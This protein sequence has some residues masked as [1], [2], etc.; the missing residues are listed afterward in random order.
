MRQPLVLLVLAASIAA[1]SVSGLPS[2]VRIVGAERA[3]SGDV[4]PVGTYS[5]QITAQGNPM[6][7][8]AVVEKHED[9]TFGGTVT[10]ESFPP[11]TIK[12]VVVA[13]RNVKLTVVSPDGSDAMVDIT[14]DENNDVTGQWSMAGDGSA[15]TGKKLS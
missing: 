11:L 5:L 2:V 1:A 4:N 10:G 12:S 9:G 15:V 3:A 7:I 6:V 13:A 14:I 8:R